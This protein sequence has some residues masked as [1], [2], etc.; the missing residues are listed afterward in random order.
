MP[1]TP[2]VDA[3]DV[4]HHVVAKGSGG[5]A[6]V[7]DDYDRQRLLFHVS[8]V[9]HLHDWVCLAYCVLDTHFHLVVSTQAPNLGRGMQQLLAPYAR[10]FNV[11]HEREGN[12]F[13]TRFYSK[14]IESDE[15]LRSSIVYVFLNP[16]RAGVAQRP[17]RWDWSSYAATMGLA[18]PPSFVAINDVLGLLDSDLRTAR[19]RL[20]LAVSESRQR[21]FERPGVRRGV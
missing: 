18:V 1:R 9:T 3:A 13:H 10:E 21:D 14:R 7:R 6:I 12:L 20:E 19:L 8:R 2:R 17:E 11:R 15:H 5:E 4:F 16:V